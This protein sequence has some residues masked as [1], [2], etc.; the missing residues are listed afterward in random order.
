VSQ[1]VDYERLSKQYDQAS[2]ELAESTQSLKSL[3]SASFKTQ[4]TRKTLEFQ[5]QDL[6]QRLRE[7]QRE[8]EQLTRDRLE[9]E[10]NGVAN[11]EVYEKMEKLELVFVA[12]HPGAGHI[13]LPA[14]QL[15]DY[16]DKPLSFAAQKCSVTLEHYKSWLVHYDGSECEECGVPVKRIDTPSDYQIG[17]NNR[18]T[19]H[20]LDSGN[21]TL[22]RRSS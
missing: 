10:D 11:V 4:E 8:N 13:S 15:E 9:A 2:H 16:L 3:T 5:A 22:F 17:V 14:R 20:R 12:Y 18:C 21:V 6:E 1:S 7:S 19:K